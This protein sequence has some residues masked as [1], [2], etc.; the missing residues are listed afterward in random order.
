MKIFRKSGVNRVM[1]KEEFIGKLQMCYFGDRNA[2]NEIVGE[3]DRLK[4]EYERIYNENCKLR[5]QHNI[6]DISLLDENNRLNNIINELEKWLKKEHENGYEVYYLMA[7]QD[8]L[9]KLKELKN[10]DNN[11]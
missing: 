11:E 1:T 9:N 8:I 3:Y 7:I 6:N 10:G 5:E 4:A 2:F